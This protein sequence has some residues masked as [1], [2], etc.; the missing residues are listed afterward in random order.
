MPAQSRDRMPLY[1]VVIAILA[2]VALLSCE[3]AGRFDRPVALG[4]ARELINRPVCWT[5]ET[6]DVVNRCFVLDE[7]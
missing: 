2:W 6:V 5:L 3:A 4:Q 1:A 7:P